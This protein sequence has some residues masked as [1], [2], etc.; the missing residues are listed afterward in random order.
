MCVRLCVYQGNEMPVWG[1]VADQLGC[2]G[3]L[4]VVSHGWKKNH[5]PHTPLFFLQIDSLVK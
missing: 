1:L 5:T 4:C 2:L 3:D